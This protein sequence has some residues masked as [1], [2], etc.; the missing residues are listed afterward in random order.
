MSLRLTR[1]GLGL[2]GAG[3]A[4]AA[5][6]TDDP[7][8]TPTVVTAGENRLVVGSQQ[9]YS[10][11]IVAELYAQALE[12]TGLEVTRQYQIGQ[13][14]VYLPELRRGSIDVFPE[15]GGALLKALDKQTAARTGAE[16]QAA[17][18]AALGSN[19]RALAPAAA[20]DQDSFTVL[21]ATAQQHGLTAIPDLVALPQP[22]RIAA[23]SEFQSRPYG[24]A[25]VKE[26]YGVELEL[27]PVEDSGG[28]LTIKALTDGTVQVADVYTATPAITELDLVV[29]DDPR[30]LILPQHLTPIVSPRVTA[31]AAAAIERVSAALTMDDLRALNARSVVEKLRSSEIAATWLAQKGLR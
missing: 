28:P 21:K 6:A 16:I 11:E 10:N 15:Y 9:Y 19:L 14:E 20:S 2:L 27:V 5:C 22:V 12:K 26:A 31:E 29:L 18:P 4:L 23:N 17:L 3:A 25:A 13:R 7:L 8:G 1:R 24:P 30:S